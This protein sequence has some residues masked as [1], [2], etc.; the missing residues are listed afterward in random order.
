MKNNQ[1]QE[2]EKQ[3]KKNT[4]MTITCL[5]KCA[6]PFIIRNVAV[7]QMNKSHSISC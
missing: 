2:T 1:K 7:F 3:E 6:G 4:K 5:C